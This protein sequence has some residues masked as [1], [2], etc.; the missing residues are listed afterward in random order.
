MSIDKSYLGKTD[1][2]SFGWT[3]VSLLSNDLGRLAQIALKYE[4]ET[5]SRKAF[6]GLTLLDTLQSVD[7][8]EAASN[9]MHVLLKKIACL[10]QYPVYGVGPRQIL[11]YNL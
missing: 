2:A 9:M 3:H 8:A 4:R 5:W 6:A 1:R 7:G 10:Q 11:L